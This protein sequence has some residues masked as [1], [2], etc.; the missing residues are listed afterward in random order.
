VKALFQAAVERPPSERDAFLAS[1]T[2][3]DVE[4]RR[5]VESLLASDASDASFLD[6]LPLASAS[7]L[8]DSLA[9]PGASIPAV[10][11]A[12]FAAGHRVG[13]CEIIAPLGAGGMGEVYR[14]RD[15]KLHRDVALKVLPARF[16]LDPDRSA[17][18]TREAQLLATLNHP[19]IGA[20]YGL[21]ES[22]PSTGS[23]QVAVRALV[24]ELVEGPTLADRIARGPLPPGEALAIARQVADALQ[25]AHEKGIIHRDLKPANIKI[26]PDDVVKVLD[27]GLARVWDGA[28]QSDLSVSPRLTAT[29][30]GERAILGTPTYMSP[31]QARGQSLDRR[32]DIWAFGCV[33]YEML[34]GRAPFAGDTISDTLAAILEREPD[35]GALPAVVPPTVRALIRRCLDKDRRQRIADISTVQFVL[36]DVADVASVAA[37][38]GSAATAPRPAMMPSMAMLSAAWLV[39]AAMV[40]GAIWFARPATAP[41]RLSRLEF[42]PPSTAALSLDRPALAVTPDGTRIV[43]ASASPE[44]LYVRALDQRDVTPLTRL[45]E[46]YGAFVSADGQWVG[47]FEGVSSLN[48][49]AITG[50]P[51]T[52]I[53]RPGGTAMGASWGTDGTIVFATNDWAT[54]LQRIADTGGEPTVLTRPNRARGEGDHVWPEILPGGQAVLFTITSTTRGLGQAQIAVLDLRTRAQTVLIRGGSNAR[55]VSS[56]HLVYAAAGRLHAVA[57]DLGRLALVGTPVMIQPEVLPMPTQT[58]TSWAVAADGTLVYAS[59]DGPI[60]ERSLVWVDRQGRET[61]IPGAPSRNYAFP[62]LSPDGRRIAVYIPDQEI[63]IWLLDLVRPTFRRATL[64]PTVDIFPV[65]R[66]DRQ[67]L[68]SSNREGGVNLFAQ[69]ADGSGG[70]T[71]LTTS[72]NVHHANSISP[73]GTRLVFTETARTTAQDILELRLDGTGAVKPLVVTPAS[74]RNAEVSPD[75]RWLAYEANDS[76]RY[77]I[78]IRPYPDVSSGGP[79]QVTTDGGTRPLWSRNSQELFYLNLTGDLMRAGVAPGKTWGPTTPTRLFEGRRYGATASQRGRTYDVSPDGSRFLMIKAVARQGQTAATAS[80]VVVQNWA[81]DLKRLVPSR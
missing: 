46:P 55:Y 12:V 19:N 58:D 70:V 40:G 30:I 35:W 81:E 29:G 74:E 24:L 17:R 7:V 1:A 21:D 18:F 64:D 15:T 27:F 3:D 8:A 45:G 78:Y 67:L 34:T 52:T 41:P 68:F 10:S 66:D 61:P 25:A 5:E 16:A 77:D 6:R 73:D 63:D 80:L 50:G 79:W 14:A 76:G 65:W 38:G 60:V 49:V 75:G 44:G 37:P 32:S 33:L 72:P 62:R 53:G 31:E 11:H 51:V 56:G 26:A 20:I 36:D 23:G 9:A 69:A 4:L 22:N 57:F 13:S 43:Y 59:G 54:G 71:R 48:R 39:G 28:L 42:T 47:F 2:S